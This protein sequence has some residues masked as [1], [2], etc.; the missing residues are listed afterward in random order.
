VLINN[1]GMEMKHCVGGYVDRVMGGDVF[2]YRVL[3][4]ERAT[5]E[6]Q[7]LPD[8]KFRIE[9]VKLYRNGKASK[10]TLNILNQW[11]VFQC[12]K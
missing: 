12:L 10:A 6:V 7:R 4:P 3:A 8:E 1:E 5:M 9:Q 11:I 2:I